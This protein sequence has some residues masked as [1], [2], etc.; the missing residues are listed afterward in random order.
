MPD[1]QC[2]A[3]RDSAVTQ[4]RRRAA[5]DLAATVPVYACAEHTITR[6]AAS[7][8]HAAGCPA[9]DPAR[10]PDCGCTPEPLPAPEPIVTGDTITLDTGW[11]VPAPEAT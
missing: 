10:L 4:W 8:V 9:P 2:G 7:R 5:D 6:D 3:C 1:I 11:V